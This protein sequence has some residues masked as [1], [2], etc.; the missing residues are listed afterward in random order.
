MVHW[1]NIHV[2]QT[3]REN[4]KQQQWKVG[5]MILAFGAASLFAQDLERLPPPSPPKALDA[6]TLA[7]RRA[8]LKSR[9]ANIRQAA[10]AAATTN[11]LAQ[12]APGR[13]SGLD[14]GGQTNVAKAGVAA[15]KVPNVSTPAVIG[16][17][18]SV[19]TSPAVGAAPSPAPT[20]ATK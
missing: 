7:A 14:S 8:T 5:T 15:V 11:G 6:E 18:V 10:N 16:A 13:N 3:R 2:R 12:G 19:G 9:V 20:P 1:R 4:M 17:A